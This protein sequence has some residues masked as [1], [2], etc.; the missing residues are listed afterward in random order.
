M[1][2][3]LINFIKIC[4]FHALK[5]TVKNVQTTLTLTEKIFIIHIFDEEL[6]CDKEL[7]SEY[8]Q[9]SYSSIQKIQQFN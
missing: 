6:V 9:N 8:T 3:K 2:Q 7:V 5:N 4:N 1:K